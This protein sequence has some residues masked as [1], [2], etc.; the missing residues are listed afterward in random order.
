VKRHPSLVLL[1]RE[2][3]D[4]LLL[5]TRLQQGTKALPRLWSHDPL[6]QAE[7]VVSFFTA[8][9]GNHF[10]I[11]EK[12]L[13]PLAAQFAGEK[14]AALIPGLVREHRQMEEQVGLFRRPDAAELPAA[15]ARFG[16]ILERH[17]R[18]EERQFFPL[19]EEEIP[20]DALKSLGER[21]AERLEK[22]A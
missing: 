17:I 1:S 15:L 16:K 19:C 2:H 5:A 12:M 14:A 7:Y 3:H 20:A 10:D 9:L 13:F 8:H 21:I 6:W 22:D 18:S 11:E 4:G